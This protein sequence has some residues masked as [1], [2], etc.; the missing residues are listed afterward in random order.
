MKRFIAGGMF[1][2]LL[3]V[4]VFTGD[5]AAFYVE[6]LMSGM[7]STTA[8]KILEKFGYEIVTI[9]EDGDIVARNRQDASRM[10]TA[11]FCSDRLVQIRNDYEPKFSRFVQL[12]EEK[13]KSLGGPVS[14]RVIP[15]KGDL[16]ADADA[17]SFAWTD[18]ETMVEVMYKVS[19]TGAQ[20]SVFHR[21][22]Q[23]CQ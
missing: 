4:P 2:S 5:A 7:S 1:L 18:K 16:T 11:E 6:G 10:I 17:V 9:Q 21:V 13:R 20:V 8:Q 14:A 22:K 15:A 3:M 23:S 19:E 12:V